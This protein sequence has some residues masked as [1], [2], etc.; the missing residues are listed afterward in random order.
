MEKRPLRN[1]GVFSESDYKG[2]TLEEATKYAED[3]G[4]TVR[5]AEQDGDAKMLDMS[6]RGDRINFRVRAGYVTAAFGG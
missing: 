1:F 2:K 4:F 6:V 3:G 5:I